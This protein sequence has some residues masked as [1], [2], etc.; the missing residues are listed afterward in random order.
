M[1][2]VYGRNFVLDSIAKVYLVQILDVAHAASLHAD[3]F[4]TYMLLFHVIYSGVTKHPT[5]NFLSDVWGVSSSI[6]H[7]LIIINIKI[8]FIIIIIYL[9]LFFIY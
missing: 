7:G 4:H 9:T 1:L 2:T 8:S 3:A 5:R 6:A